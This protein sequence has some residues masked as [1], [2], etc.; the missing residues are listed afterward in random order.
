MPNLE[1]TWQQAAVLAVGLLGAAVV[2]RVADAHRLPSAF[3]VLREAGIIAALFSLWQLA[4]SLAVVHTA[5]A[6]DRARQVVRL[7][8]DWHLP[9]EADIQHLVLPHHWLAQLCNLYYAG[10]H[11]LALGALLVWLFWRHRS[12]YARIRT[13]LVLLTAACLL[14]QLIPVAPPR[15]LAGYGFVDLAA[16]YGQSVYA[17]FPTADQFSAMPSVHVGWAVLIGWAAVT[18]GTGPWRWASLLHPIITVFV[19]VAT[20]NHFWLDGIVAVALLVLAEIVRRLSGRL[21]L[22]WLDTKNREL[23]VA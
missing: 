14:I 8:R 21:V 12:A 13:T 3:P 18:V 9:S 17:A 19:V 2:C 7:E 15:L 16:Q 11:F 23:V 1:L 6:F 4:G 5:G 10:V 22:H 20:G